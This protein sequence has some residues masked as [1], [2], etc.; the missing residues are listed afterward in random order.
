MALEHHPHPAAY[1]PCIYF[2]H[3]LPRIFTYFM[4]ALPRLNGCRGACG[5]FAMLID[6]FASCSPVLLLPGADLNLR[7]ISQMDWMYRHKSSCQLPFH[8]A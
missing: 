1:R 7:V 6:F 5:V 2:G 3:V 4:P 8:A